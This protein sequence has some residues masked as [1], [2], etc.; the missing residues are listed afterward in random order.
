LLKPA[1]SALLAMLWALKNGGLD[2]AGLPELSRLAASGRTS[3]PV[4]AAIAPPLYRVVGYR[5]AGTRAVRIDILERLADLIR[6]L[7]AW[8]PTA[9]APN[10]PP[11][12]IN[13]YGFTATVTMTSLLGCSGE[14]FAS[15]LRALGYRAER[16]PVPPKPE[17]PAV[18]AEPVP[19]ETMLAAEPP[20]SAAAEAPTP[21]PQDASAPAVAEEVPATGPEAVAAPEATASAEVP[22][23]P[24]FIEVWRPGRKERENQPPRHRRPRRREAPAAKETAPAAPDG[25]GAPA[26]P[27]STADTQSERPQQHRR[28]DR[29]ERDG[30]RGNRGPRPQGRHGK[31]DGGRRERDDRPR[32]EPR[33]AEP[34]RFSTEAPKPDKRNRVA[35]PTSPFA[36]LAALKAE[37]EAKERGG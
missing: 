17:T 29:N 16:K 18:V 5:P 30:E 1:P 22:A 3:V 24:Q 20:E 10:P 34:V 9:E 15:V 37:L 32:R 35:D 8:R 25:A 27:A 23:E 36:A 31:P 7:I 33:S 26:Q 12:A 13:G 28:R 14:D 6:P 4:D 19:T 2:I 21:E 11:G